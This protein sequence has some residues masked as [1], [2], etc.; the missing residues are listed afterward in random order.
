MRPINAVAIAN[1]VILA[2]SYAAAL[3]IVRQA[4]GIAERM[5]TLAQEA[6]DAKR[7][8]DALFSQPI[9]ADG[10]WEI[11]VMH[12][13]LSGVGGDYFQVRRDAGRTV[14]FVADVSGKGIQAAMLLA[15]LK[16]VFNATSAAR[17]EPG[18]ALR[19]FNRSLQGL[20]M[21]EM[22]ATA[23][24]AVLA[25]DGGV[26]YAS[27][28]HE[29]ALRRAAGGAL[30]TLAGGGLPLGVETDADVEEFAAQLAPGETL[31]AYSDGVTSLLEA[32]VLRADELF[33]DFDEVKRRCRR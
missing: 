31:L 11:D 16:A 4:R 32:G 30:Q 33:A 6:A 23:W 7:V 10:A 18:A 22:F 26:C 12:L 13:P 17:I 19:A 3:V 27:A 15:A 25:D 14:A 24:L 5:T 9:A 8:H 29:P 21:S 1:G 2:L 20:V 28:G